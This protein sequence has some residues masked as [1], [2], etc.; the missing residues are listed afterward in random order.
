[1]SEELKKSVFSLFAQAQMT[2][3]E[4]EEK[5]KQEAGKPKV[6]RFRIGEDGE[7]T[8]R[9]LPLAPSIDDEGNAQPM[10]RKGYEYPIHQL[11]LGINLPAKKGKK[12]K[13]INIPVLRATDKGIDKSVDLID[14]YVRIAKELYA[15][16]EDLLKVVTGGSF[17]GGLRWSYQHAMYVIDLSTDKSRAKGP[18]LWQC[19]HSQYRTLDDAKLR[20]WSELKADDGQDTCPI[21]WF[22]DA[23]PVKVI[24]KTETK[25]EYT[26]EIGRKT[27]DV[28]ED[29]VK[30]LLDLPRI[31]EL[32]NR[33]TRYQLEAELVFLEQYDEL[34]QMEV[35]KEADFIEAVEKLKGE[36][37]ADDTSHFDIASAGS[38]KEG[39][40]AEVTIDSL[41]IE[42]DRIVDE[43][44]SEHSDEYQELR[45][46]IRQFAEDNE[47][48]VRLARSK[49]NQQ[50]LSEIEKAMDDKLHQAAPAPKAEENDEPE[51]PIEEKSVDEVSTRCRRPRP[52]MDEPADEP[53]ADEAAPAEE[54]NNDDEEPAEETERP[55]HRRRRR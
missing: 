48:D 14:T 31:P 24:R 47:L 42:Y 50:L 3:S 33:F 35:C 9:I 7:Y 29:E 53:E 23:Y 51:A 17:G 22:T 4:A 27:L 36:M 32:V 10:E 41:W 44:L 6:E 40:T 5:A 19:S 8:I 37:P 39:K 52:T 18:Q 45:E 28:T 43:G 20:L 34:H 13:K 54:I 49:N 38:D 55:L 30:K 25:T 12:S 26:I 46:K 2:F 16:D 1:M 21:S 11:F 15:D